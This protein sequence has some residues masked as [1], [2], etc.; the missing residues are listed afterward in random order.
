MISPQLTHPY[1]QDRIQQ[2]EDCRD[3][4]EG[5]SAI[6]ARMEAK[7]GGLRFADF[8][9]QPA[10]G[11]YVEAAKDLTP[12]AGGEIAGAPY[13]PAF[14]RTLDGLV[15]M[16]LRDPP[17]VSGTSIDWKKFFEDVD[18]N[19]TPLAGFGEQVA[20]ALLMTGR[21][22]VYVNAK[23]VA[24]G[25]RA[26]VVWSLRRTEDLVSWLTTPAGALAYARLR[27]TR[28]VP[29]K[30]APEQL[31][32]VESLRIVEGLADPQA[33]Q[34]L[35]SD[36]F[37]QRVIVRQMAASDPEKDAPAGDVLE[38]AGAFGPL[39]S[40]PIIVGDLPADDSSPDLRPPKPPMLDLAELALSHYQTAQDLEQSL[41][42]AG[43]PQPYVESSRPIPN[44]LVG[45]NRM[46]RVPPGAKL[47]M[48]EASGMGLAAQEK[49]LERKSRQMAA[50]GGRLIDEAVTRHAETATAMKLKSGGDRSILGMVAGTTE[51][52]LERALAVTAEWNGDAGDAGD[53]ELTRDYVDAKL[54]ADEVRELVALRQAD[55]ISAEDLRRA[56]ISGRV[57]A[58][59]ADAGGNPADE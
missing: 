30:D 48:L 4:Y 21:A 10:V 49:A 29:K 11:R 39:L 16:I 57:I 51:R 37:P 54:T 15:G 46:L 36:A 19:G 35:R 38:R 23:A 56:L 40:F 1:Y 8:S 44:L 7:Q 25:M 59:R 32:K 3:A 42:W 50:I 31:E 5:A 14:A 43:S 13:Y 53:V 17:K 58:P 22:V 28:I 55:Q 9:A 26:R 2:W 47:G 34:R 12:S 27:E 6:R 20:R 18:G 52:T 24:G 41:H 45:P 33:N